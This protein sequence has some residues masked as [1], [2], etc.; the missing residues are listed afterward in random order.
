M[1]A[2]VGAFLGLVTAVGAAA[3][4]DAAQGGLAADQPRSPRNANYTIAA[5]LNP[6]ARTIDGDETL[7]WRNISR[8]PAH[9]IQ[10]HLYYNAWRDERSTWMRER[11]LSV[12]GP[13]NPPRRAGEW[14]WIDVDSVEAIKRDGLVDIA[15]GPLRYIGPD[16]GNP[17][18]RTVAEIPLSASVQPGQAIALRIRWRSHIPRTFA[19]TGAIADYFFIAQWF[20]KVGV[21]EDS[22]W[23]CHQFHVA[24]EFFSDFGVYDVK[25][26]VPAGWTTGATGTARAITKE[27]DG[28]ETHAY[29]QEDVHDFAWTTSPHYLERH[30]TFEHATLPRVDMRLLLQP[31]HAGQEG[32]HF[33]ATRAALRYY[34][35]WFGAYPYGHITIV[36]PAWQSGAGGMEYP[37]LFTAGTRWL[38]PRSTLTPEGV[39]I[40]EAGHQFWYGIVATNEFEDAWMDEGINTYSTARVI[41]QV[42]EPNYYAQR[43]FAGFV[44]WVFRDLPLTRAIDGDR[45]ASYRAAARQDVESTQTFHYWPPTSGA[46]T[47]SKTALWLHTLE[48]Y[49]GRATHQRIMS[50]YFQRYGFKHPKPAD[51][52]SVATEVSG[53]DL[54]WFF[55][56]VYRGS[57]TFDYGVDQFRSDRSGDSFHTM[58][59]A[60]R[61]GDGV[62]PVDVQVTHEN[63]QQSHWTWDGRDRWKQFQA[64]GASR[65]VRV[66]IDPRRVLALDVN[67]TNNSAALDP[68]GPRAA[69][70][71]SLAWLVWLQDHLLTYGFFV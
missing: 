51:F 7:T 26:T 4:L 55:D 36:D 60:R 20:P 46:I 67:R 50:T 62:F 9:T 6:A 68:A 34:G 29:F 12:S 3:S 47:Y 27:S 11:A 52:F 41:E 37:T 24:T 63:G 71:W 21:L 23:N 2:R 17:D 35:E 31:E 48:N 13:E 57:Q 45:M 54:T 44:P 49:L 40:H 43:Y 59:A 66:E 22:G 5:R 10:L 14:G 16:D 56:Q 28:S 64:D 19:R 42:Y 69:H 1:L 38:A 15:V 30:A 39:T 65:A 18:D 70:K 58:V 33:D 25:L 8:R 32:R 53:Q 61:Y